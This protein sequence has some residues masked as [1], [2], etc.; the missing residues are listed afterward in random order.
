MSVMYKK[1]NGLRYNKL[2]IHDLMK[3]LVFVI[4]NTMYFYI[5][6]MNVHTDFENN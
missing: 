2:S 4:D 5:L 6:E 3:A 1:G